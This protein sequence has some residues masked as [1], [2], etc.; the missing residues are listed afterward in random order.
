MPLL[1]TLRPLGGLRWILLKPEVAVPI[2]EGTKAIVTGSSC[3]SRHVGELR[4]HRKLDAG[5]S[6]FARIKRRS[7]RAQHYQKEKVDET[8]G[9]ST[10]A[11]DYSSSA[12]IRRIICGLDFREPLHADG[13]DISDPVLERDALD[14]V[15]H[16]AIPE[17]SLKRDELPLLETPGELREIPPGIDAMP[18]GAVLVVALVVLPAFLGCDVEDDELFVVLSGF[19]FRVLSEAADEDDFVEHLRWLRFSGLSAVCGVS[20]P[21]GCAVAT[22]SLGDW[23]GSVEGELSERDLGEIVEGSVAMFT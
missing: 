13:M 3:P 5:R 8:S 7:S 10:S 20:L 17:N 19:G 12:P 6:E 9:S 21:N 16:L 11:G 14:L 23:R 2:T 1:S 4:Y 18:F 15:F 22:H